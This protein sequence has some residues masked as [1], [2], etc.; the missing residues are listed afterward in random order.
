MVGRK[1]PSPTPAMQRPT[2]KVGNVE[3]THLI[4]EPTAKMKPPRANVEVRDNLSD[5]GPAI[6]DAADAVAKIMET[7]K[8]WRNG[9][10]WHNL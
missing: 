7:I 4:T 8:P 10:L 3:E 9:E 6:R 5:K 2:I 1:R